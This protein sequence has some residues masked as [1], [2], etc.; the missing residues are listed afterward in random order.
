MGI[1]RGKVTNRALDSGASRR[2][3]EMA[4]P[5]GGRFLL[6][7]LAGAASGL[8]LA[9]TGGLEGAAQSPGPPQGPAPLRPP[10]LGPGPPGARPGP[11][12][13]VPPAVLERS[14][15]A[16]LAATRGATDPTVLRAIAVGAR[17]ARVRVA[18]LEGLVAADGG[19][20]TEFLFGRVNDEEEAEK[21]RGAAARLLGRTGPKGQAAVEKLLETPRPRAV[22]V[23]ALVAQA[24]LDA[25]GDSARFLRRLAGEAPRVQ[26]AVLRSLERTRPEAASRVALEG[27]LD[28]MLDAGPPRSYAT[29]SRGAD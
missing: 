28:P 9:L 12:P 17:D 24:A 6:F 19:A 29:R 15:A 8:L 21:V 20:A 13:A 7:L 11:A 16:A 2:G 1:V 4:R 23:G 5:A 10:P 14:L 27:L 22:R 26:R 25:R 18:T 3:T